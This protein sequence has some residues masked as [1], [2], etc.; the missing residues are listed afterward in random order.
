MFSEH[1]IF[2]I[3]KWCLGCP[4]S[5]PL[6]SIMPRIANVHTAFL[7]AA[8][9]QEPPHHRCASPSLGTTR[10]TPLAKWPVRKEAVSVSRSA[11]GRCS[12][13][14]I[15]GSPQ[16]EQGAR[17]GDSMAQFTSSSGRGPSGY[18]SSGS[19]NRKRPSLPQPS[20][21][22]RGTFS[23]SPSRMTP[24]PLLSSGYSGANHWPGRQPSLASAGSNL[25]LWVRAASLETQ[26]SM[27][28]W[29]GN[30][31]SLL[32]RGVWNPCWVGSDN[33]HQRPNTRAYLQG[34]NRNGNASVEH[35]R[36]DD[37]ICFTDSLKAEATTWHFRM[38]RYCTS[39]LL[40]WRAEY[41]LL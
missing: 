29:R 6:S 18:S 8:R 30:K 5:H 11:S 41:N 21:Q 14:H 25:E 1:P 32:L 38:A 40:T 26:G 23:R 36:L 27:R 9:P 33:V 2:N 37:S 19:Q 20:L 15:T 13:F 35:L 4:K 17:P 28:R 3:I 39:T 24:W 31:T 22:E 16:V 10:W 7:A 34:G 12:L